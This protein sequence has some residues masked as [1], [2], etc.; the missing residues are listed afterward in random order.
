MKE[1]MVCVCACVCVCVC[2]CVCLILY[3]LV[4]EAICSCGPMYEIIV[5][6]LAVNIIT[7]GDSR[8]AVCLALLCGSISEARDCHRAH[9]AAHVKGL[10]LFLCYRLPLTHTHTYTKHYLTLAM[11]LF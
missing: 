10:G 11:R 6:C 5:V 8:R 9:L 2:V 1:N 7:M 3:L 4:M